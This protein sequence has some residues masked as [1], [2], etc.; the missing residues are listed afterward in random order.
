MQAREFLRCLRRAGAEI[1]AKRGKG[2]HVL[3]RYKGRSSTV[4]VHGG[5]DL[6]PHFLREVCKQLGLKPQEVL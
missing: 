5:L 4:P 1:V 6:D 2:S 3:V